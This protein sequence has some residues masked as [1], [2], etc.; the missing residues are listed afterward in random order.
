MNEINFKMRIGAISNPTVTV[1]GEAVKFEKSGSDY[2]GNFKTDKDTVELEIFRYHEMS[3]KL[4]WL[5]SLLFFIVSVFGI[6][7]MRLDRHGICI[8]YKS[9]LHLKE[10]SEVSLS[11]NRP[12][13]GKKAVE[14][15]C[16]CEAEQVDNAFYTDKT[17]KK[18]MKI[19]LAV[20]IVL[21]IALLAGIVVGV[22][23]GIIGA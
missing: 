16:D 3:G 13:D 23:F 17:I 5:F 10:K 9:I 6:F 22:V 18:R 14:C 4:W 21:W 11:F 12:I 7:D 1:D 2:V 15:R 19:M 20:K 8:K